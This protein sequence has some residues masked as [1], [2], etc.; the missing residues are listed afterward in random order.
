MKYLILFI[1][2]LFTASNSYASCIESHLGHQKNVFGMD[3]CATPKV[4]KDKFDYV[5]AIAAEYIDNNSDGKADDPKMEQAL[6]QNKAILLVFATKEESENFDYDTL[7][8][9]IGQDL[10]STEIFMGQNNGHNFDASIEE[11][12]HLITVAGYGMIYPEIFGDRPGTIVAKAMDKARGGFFEEI[13]NTYPQNSWYS[14]DD[15]TC[16]YDCQVSEYFYWALTSYLGAQ[17]PL[18]RQKE[19]AHEWRAPTRETLEKLD[20]AVVQ[21]ITNKKYFIPQKLPDG[22]YP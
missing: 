3:I 18:W 5:I 9:R 22:I 13:P 6:R 12:L 7:D 4:P 15:Q 21:L 11:V 19:I 10:Y 20:P 16:E 8:Q 1:T 17:K 2:I 14:Y